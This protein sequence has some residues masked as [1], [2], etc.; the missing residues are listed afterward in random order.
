[1]TSL[2]VLVMT[3]VHH[4][5]DTRILVRQI[6][7]LVDAGHQVTYA[8]P[9]S[10]QGVTAPAG[11]HAVDLPRSSGR[12]RLAAVRAAR[13][14]VRELAARHD[15]VLIHDP[16]LVFSVAGVTDVPVVWDVHEDTAAAVSYK[17]WIPVGL[18]RAVAAG[19]RMMERWA[20]RRLDL[21][22]AEAGYRDRF[23]LP[24][25][26]VPNSTLVAVDAPAAG[27]GR[28]VCVSTLTRARGALDL[29]EVGRLLRPAGIVLDLIGPAAPDVI[30]ELRRADIDGDVRWYGR[31]PHEDV[32]ER[33][34]GATAGLSLLH[35]ERNYRH[36]HPTK[37]F[38]YLAQ[39]LP[40]VATPLPLVVEVVERHEVGILVPFRDPEAAAA[41]VIDL[42]A[43]D[44]GRIS[45][46]RNGIAAVRSEHNWADDAPLF[47]AAI[48]E[49]ARRRSR[50]RASSHLRRPR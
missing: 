34:R 3:V 40:V 24:H 6:S 47:V 42:N 28:V 1:M 25:P 43:N 9:F 11:V 36:S 15:V 13:R 14:T 18:D 21:L 20:E 2:R 33:M 17:D 31:L 12:Q 30:E 10:A 23:R 5:Q 41:A 48:E 39:G 32:M 38:E 8:A 50:G 49:A 27:T 26:V 29:I 4:P 44:E 37:V 35:N 46:G 7:A 45:M 19:V 16:E 22:L